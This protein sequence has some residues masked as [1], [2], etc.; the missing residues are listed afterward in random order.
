[1][2]LLAHLLSTQ[3]RIIEV[4]AQDLELAM[5]FR[6]QKQKYLGLVQDTAVIRQTLG[7]LPPDLESCTAPLTG[8]TQLEQ[9]NAELLILSGGFERYLWFFAR[10]AHAHTVAWSPGATLASILAGLG[11]LKNLLLRRVSVAGLERVRLPSGQLRSLLFINI[12]KRKAVHA[13]RHLSPKLGSELFFRKLREKN[14]TYTLLRWFEDMPEVAEG[15]DLDLL[16]ADE[17][18][19]TV[20]S[21]LDEEPGT[22]PFDL[23]SVSGLPS[24][25]YKGMAYYPPPL[26]TKLLTTSSW[27]K[28]WYRVPTPELHFLSLAYHALYHKGYQAGLANLQEG[29]STKEEAHDYEGTLQRLAVELGLDIPISMESLN[30]YLQTKGWQ[31]G[32]DTVTRLA[33]HNPW[34]KAHL[35][36]VTKQQDDAYA[37]L[38]VFFI[39][40]KALELGYDKAILESLESEGFQLLS[41]Q[42]L[43]AEARER[44]QRGIRGGNWGKG[45]YPSSGGGPALMVVCLD[46]IPIP[47][48]ETVTERFPAL[49]NERLLIKE[50]IRLQLNARLPSQEHCN[51]LHSSD[52][53]AE[54]THYLQVATPERVAD[55]L[56]EAKRL[57]ATFATKEP[58]VKVLTKNGRRAKLEVIHYQGGLAVKKTF[59]PGCERFL[60]REQFV[61][62]TFSPLR[63]EIPEL[64]ASGSN[65]I[66]YPYYRDTLHLSMGSH[67]PLVPLSALKKGIEVLRFFYERGYAHGDFTPGNLICDA[68]VGIKVIDFEFFHTY[69]KRPE[70]FEQS[71]DF[72]GPT[73]T[74]S[75][76]I[77][78]DVVPTYS[79]IWQPLVGLELKELLY[80]PAATQHLRRLRY[81]FFYS[82][83]QSLLRRYRTLQRSAWETARRSWRS[84][85]P[86]RL[87]ELIK[88]LLS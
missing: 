46:L 6:Q 60:E 64:L 25:D 45:A 20:A 76:D 16:V 23:Y 11:I 66:V 38:A 73:A 47:P 52:N 63:P 7:T 59:R 30:A 24:T 67:R 82:S 34:L 41:V 88:W 39:R 68:E 51:V 3:P 72:V 57:A 28:G 44:V 8:V 53:Q 55:L 71:F 18:M 37:G 78:K 77:P 83:R 84:V 13:R 58:V 62:E 85:R 14:T 35:H 1:M 87:G 70:T 48:H 17:D 69:N 42:P 9:N 2:K 19:N 86:T 10:Y 36:M 29:L 32:A 50:K 49:E 12:L 27:L 33:L 80:A 54:A 75:G 43:D 26:A 61:L 74:F 81:I 40:D 21:L 22:L 5:F 79:S 4:G 65:Y 56:S 15:E 31:P